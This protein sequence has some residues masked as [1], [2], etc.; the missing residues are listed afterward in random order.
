[1]SKS[2]LAKGNALLADRVLVLRNSV[3]LRVTDG[4]ERN[5]HGIFV[6]NANSVLVQANHVVT[7]DR[8]VPEVDVDGVKL[9]GVYGRQVIVRDNH[10]EGPRTGI[11]FAPGEDERIK[12]PSLKLERPDRVWLFACN[13]AESAAEALHCPPDL[14]AAGVVVAEHNIAP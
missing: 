6:G 12:R 9:I 8:R 5:R 11:I 13:V 1:L 2:E 4:E 14:L 7:E 10:F 3:T